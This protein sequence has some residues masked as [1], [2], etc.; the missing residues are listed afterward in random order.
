MFYFLSQFP[1]DLIRMLEHIVDGTE[2]IDQFSGCFLSDT[3]T[4]REIVCR[5]AHQCEEVDYLSGSGYAVFRFHLLFTERLVAAAMPGAVHMDIGPD[6]LAVVFV[7]S[8]HKSIDSIGTE[9]GGY[10]A[11]DIVCL[12]TVCLQDRDVHGFENLLDDGN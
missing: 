4:A 6:Q 11:D 10:R 8:E 3:G 9:P 5:V 1:F 12:E 2:L 7:G